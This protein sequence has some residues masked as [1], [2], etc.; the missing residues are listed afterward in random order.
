MENEKLKL[1]N[2]IFKNKILEN[3]NTQLKQSIEHDSNKLKDKFALIV[4]LIIY[5]LTVLGLTSLVA[6]IYNRIRFRMATN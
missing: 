3:E 6:S 1:H 4:F 2:Q 5:I